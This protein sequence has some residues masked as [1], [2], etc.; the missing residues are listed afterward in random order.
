[1]HII[2]DKA[3]NLKDDLHHKY[4]AQLSKLLNNLVYWKFESFKE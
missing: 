4:E 2:T 3:D 1:M